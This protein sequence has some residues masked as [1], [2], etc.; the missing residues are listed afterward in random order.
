[1]RLTVGTAGHIDHGK[2]ALV[3]ALTGIDCDRLAEEKRRGI[4]IDLG[5]AHL[6]EGELQISFV[7]VPGH[8]RF[9]RNALAGLGGI[10]T[11]MLVVAADEG[12]KPQT[13][14]HLQICSLLEIPAGLAVLTKADLVGEDLLELALLEL[15]EEL[16]GSPFEGAP[17]VAASSTTGRGLDELRRRLFELAARDEPDASLFAQPA[18]LPIDR[19]FHLKGLGVVIT[20]TLAQGQVRPGDELELLPGG[21]EARVRSVQVHGAAREVA[22]AGE[23]VSLQLAGVGLADVAR[24]TQAVAPGAFIATRRLLVRCRLLEDAPAAISSAAPVRFHLYSSERVGKLRPLEGQALEPGGEALCGVRLDRPVVAARGD[25]FVVRRPSPQRTLGGGRVLDPEWPAQRGAGLAAALRVLSGASDDDALRH[26]VERAGPAGLELRAIARRFGW[27]RDLVDRRL[28]EHVE[29]G[30]MLLAPAGPGHERRWIA[31]ATYRALQERAVEVL[32]A[33]HAQNRM[34]LGMPKAEAVAAI[35]GRRGAPLAD[36]YLD[37]LRRDRTLR[38]DGE[39]VT[40]PGRGSSLTEQESSL[41]ER[42]A[43]AFE[44]R[45]LAAPSLEEIRAE[46]SA[47]PKVF[48]GLVRHLVARGRVTRLPSGLFVATA[49]L[50]RL[51]ADLLASGWE[52]F[53]VGEFKDRFGLSRK[54]AIPLLEYLDAQGATRRVGDDRQVVRRPA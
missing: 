48:E 41:A 19:A 16:R 33:Y 4:T 10:R 22:A 30:R 7:D 18:R 13:R 37:W 26:F 40:L 3:K 32:G 44:K 39:R 34:A 46:V 51:R 38:F 17:I 6:E 8:E 24:G 27:S 12:V 25:R 1:M 45:G 54:W 49:A 2:T 20:G 9:V 23:R 53:G 43:A 5:F 35:V 47:A 31:P 14:E 28:Q 15:E 50:E 52:R 11:M 36:V 42:I 21:H 29:S